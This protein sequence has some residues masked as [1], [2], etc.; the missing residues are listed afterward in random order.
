MFPIGSTLFPSGPIRTA[1][2]RGGLVRRSARGRLAALK[3][4]TIETLLEQVREESGALAVTWS[5]SRGRV[6]SPPGVPW[7]AGLGGGAGAASRG[8]V[9]RLGRAATARRPRLVALGAR[10]AAVRA[11]DGPLGRCR[12]AFAAAEGLSLSDAAIEALFTALVA[13]DEQRG[14]AQE[15]RG[16]AEL[17][18][19]GHAAAS[20]AHDLRN[21]L[22]AALFELEALDAG[23]PSAALGPARGARGCARAGARLPRARG[24]ARA[25]AGRAR[26]A[27]GA[28]GRPPGA[29][30]AGQHARGRGGR[31]RAV[32]RRPR[33]PDRARRGQPARQRPRG[34]AARGERGARGRARGALGRDRARRPRARHGPGAPRALPRARCL[35]GGHRALAR[36]ACATAWRASAGSCGSRARRGRARAARCACWRPRRRGRPRRWSTMRIPSRAGAGARSSSKP[37]GRR[38]RA[39]RP[40]RPGPGSRARRWS[41]CSCR[42]ARRARRASRARPA[43]A[44][45]RVV[46]TGVR[47]A[48]GVVELPRVADRAG[49]ELLE[50]LVGERGAAR[51]HPRQYAGFV[52][53]RGALLDGLASPEPSSSPPGTRGSGARCCAT[54]MAL[55]QAASH[56]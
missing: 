4:A 23:V 52:G 49:L 31:A 12:L 40:P 48:S 32:G 26:G 46:R 22:S 53:E 56:S 33:R 20:A 54:E 50:R 25:P 30:G 14:R 29:A 34:F 19:L 15:A 9:E 11:Q 13:L 27:A 47:H 5:S 17:A 24:R 8:R 38:S 39:R 28:R 36:P 10:F 2:L 45:C 55:G 43:S 1:S 21:L 3:P 42:A 35:A 37:A 18:R 41:P 6:A 16:S 44:D 7:D 51:P